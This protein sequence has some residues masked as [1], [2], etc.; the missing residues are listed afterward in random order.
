MAIDLSSSLIIVAIRPS[1]RRLLR[2]RRAVRKSS[3]GALRPGD[4]TIQGLLYGED[5]GVMA[6]HLPGYGSRRVA[7]GEQHDRREAPFPA[8]QSGG[9][10]AVER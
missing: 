4:D 2:A 1:R 9:E 6:A 8:L 3:L 5:R 10:G 7:L